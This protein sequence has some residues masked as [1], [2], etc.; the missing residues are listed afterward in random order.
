MNKKEIIKS[1]GG[2][3][4]S[5]GIGF[6]GADLIEAAERG[7]KSK[8]K[9]C[10]ITFAGLVLGTMVID[11]TKKFFDKSIDDMLPEKVSVEVEISND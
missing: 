3:I 1:V 10:C 5:L 4:T 6:I 2:L 9:N 8:L 7:N 11:K